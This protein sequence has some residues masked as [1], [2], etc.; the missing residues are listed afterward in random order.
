MKSYAEILQE[1]R[2]RQHAREELKVAELRRVCI[3]ED[4]VA[5]Y[6]KEWKEKQ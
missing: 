3:S 1:E 2:L 5:K 4:Q 6:F